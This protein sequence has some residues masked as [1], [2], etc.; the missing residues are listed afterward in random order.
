MSECDPMS[1]AF[2]CVC[3]LAGEL[4]ATKGLTFFS[5][6]YGFLQNKRCSDGALY[7]NLKSYHPYLVCILIGMPSL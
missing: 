5:L 7:T 6:L 4:N 2:L 3:T 1:T